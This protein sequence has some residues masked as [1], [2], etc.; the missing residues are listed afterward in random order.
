MLPEEQ[1]PYQ[2]YVS[3]PKYKVE[4]KSQRFSINRDDVAA[5]LRGLG[6]ALLG[7]LL[8]WITT[9]FTP[10]LQELVEKSDAAWAAGIVASLAALLSVLVN[11]A[12][13]WLE[14]N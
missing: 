10:Y 6:I 7:A 1:K 14:G 13:K 2:I 12:R 4:K 5:L 11:A 3:D 9:V 8:T